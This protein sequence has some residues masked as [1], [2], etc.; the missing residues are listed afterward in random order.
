MEDLTPGQEQTFIQLIEHAM[1]LPPAE[2]RLTLLSGDDQ[3]PEIVVDDSTGFRLGVLRDDIWRLQSL[4]YISGQWNIDAYVPVPFTITRHGFDAY[5][6]H[7][8][9]ASGSQRIEDSI[10]RH[11]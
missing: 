1:T 3:G 4:D 10:Q 2:Q 11:L 5:K 6:D 8:S 7:Q 9:K